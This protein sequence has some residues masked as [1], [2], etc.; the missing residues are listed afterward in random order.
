MM[1]EHETFLYKLQ[2]RQVALLKEINLIYVD[3]LRRIM[4]VVTRDRTKQPKETHD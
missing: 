3:V 4:L 2:N 1:N